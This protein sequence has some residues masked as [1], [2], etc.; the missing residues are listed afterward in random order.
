MD[1]PPFTDNDGLLAKATAGERRAEDF[2]Q[3]RVVRILGPRGVA[4]SHN[5]GRQSR[6]RR[7][8]KTRESISS[9]DRSTAPVP[10]RRVQVEAQN[11]GGVNDYRA[12]HARAA[13]G[14]ARLGSRT[15]RSR[16][17]REYPR[18]AKDQLVSLGAY[19]FPK[20]P[21]VAIPTHKRE[22]Y[23]AGFFGGTAEDRTRRS[24]RWFRKWIRTATKPRE[25]R[26]RRSK[27]R[28]RPTPAGICAA[29]I[30]RSARRAVQHG[31]IVDSRFR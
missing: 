21:G 1:I 28:W 31:W 27:C 7:W 23:P 20:I 13:G 15:A 8:Q 5:A 22:A 18:I 16:R 9:L 29:R 30:D 26:C 3:Q 14:D 17:L 2:L 19:A 6:T 12:S 10:F 11:P 25:S 4:D 24:R